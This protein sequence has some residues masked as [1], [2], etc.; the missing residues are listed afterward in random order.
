MDV[1][2]ACF[3]MRE[4]SKRGTTIGDVP[5]AGIQGMFIRF[6]GSRL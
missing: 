4:I 6:F 2:R 3:E 1:E 5:V